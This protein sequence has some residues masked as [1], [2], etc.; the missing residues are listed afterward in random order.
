M[1]YLNTSIRG[2]PKGLRAG[3][4]P[5]KPLLIIPEDFHSVTFKGVPYPLQ[6]IEVWGCGDQA[7][8]K[9]QLEIKKWQVTEAERQ[10]SVKLSA[11]D[12]IEHPDSAS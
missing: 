6:N 5:R 12:W 1:L 9:T 8:R 7:S 11:A 4:D 3:S 2:Y 10:R